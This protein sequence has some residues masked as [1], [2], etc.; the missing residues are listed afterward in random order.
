MS[1]DQLLLQLAKQIQELRASLAQDNNNPVLT[2]AQVRVLLHC[3]RNRVFELLAAGHLVRARRSGRETLITRSS[4][5]RY[6]AYLLESR[7]R[8]PGR[9]CA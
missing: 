3:G 6:Q 1:P 5:E 8:V 2:V 7:G 9:R 4:V